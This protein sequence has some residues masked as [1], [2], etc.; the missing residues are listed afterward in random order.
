[1]SLARTIAVGVLYGGPSSEHEVSLKSGQAILD[2]LPDWCRGIPIF[3]DRN[4]VWYR[5]ERAMTPEEALRP[6]AV[7]VNA[8]HGEYGEDGKVQRI[9]DNLGQAYT[10]SGVLAAA[11]AMNKSRAAEH[12]FKHGLRHPIHRLLRREQASQEL[13]DELFHTFPQPSVVKPL[14]LGSSV[15]V[16]MARTRAELSQVLDSVFTLS[17]S[18]IIE[19]R[20]EGKEATCGVIENFRGEALYALPVVEIRPP[21]DKFFDY[22]AKYSGATEEIVPGRFTEEERQTIQTMAKQAHQLLGAR[23]YSRS[24][25]I[26]HPRRG[27]YMLELN[28]L[29][30]MTPESLFPKS[31]AAVGSD[32]PEFLGHIVEQ[33]QPL[34]R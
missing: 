15:G 8:L 26:I 30:G 10:G 2:N 33:V 19:E 16:G 13:V 32:L 28:T 3:I 29:P 1:M 23:H 6:V 17:A 18:A 21:A 31:L 27:V 7:A 11:L 12:C 9:L 14:S 24:D 5:R 4:G 20:I 34:T 25:F 22:E